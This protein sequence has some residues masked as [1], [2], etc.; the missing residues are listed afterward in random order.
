MKTSLSSG[1]RTPS[2]TAVAV[3]A[4]ELRERLGLLA[5]AQQRGRLVRQL[6]GPSSKAMSPAMGLMSGAV[7]SVFAVQPDT[8]S[9]TVLGVPLM[10]TASR[11]HAGSCSSAFAPSPCSSEARQRLLVVRL[12]TC[13]SLEAAA[14]SKASS[15][16]A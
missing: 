2:V 5:L 1:L 8:T 4:V 10:T 12:C 6:F 9:F 15:A 16:G 13:R 3:H 11:P 14:V 7:T